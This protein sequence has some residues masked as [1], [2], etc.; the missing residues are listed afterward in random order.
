MESKDTEE[1]SN[2]EMEL[3]PLNETCDETCDEKISHIEY[4]EQKAILD[5]I[6]TFD[7]RDIMQKIM[8]TLEELPEDKKQEF[9]NSINEIMNFQS[10]FSKIYNEDGDN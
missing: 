6:M 2:V 4:E 7:N 1:I 9:S 8:E 5:M 3:I 10:Q